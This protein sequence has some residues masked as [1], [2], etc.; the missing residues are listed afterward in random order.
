MEVE[1]LVRLRCG[2]YSW[3]CCIPPERADELS[4]F[5]R[6][7]SVSDIATILRWCQC[8]TQGTGPTQ[9]A[10]E[11]S[12]GT[13]NDPVAS[14]KAQLSTLT[15]PDVCQDAKDLICKPTVQKI[16]TAICTIISS[17]DPTKLSRP[18]SGLVQL[19]QFSCSMYELACTDDTSAAAFLLS[20]YALDDLVLR[21]VI[22]L[23]F[24]ITGYQ[25][26]AFMVSNIL[27]R[28]EAL[29]ADTSCGANLISA[30]KNITTMMQNMVTG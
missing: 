1:D 12:P 3:L 24:N 27:T 30:N 28:L 19:L 2:A 8:Q 15:L 7:H 17:A 16:V 18:Y 5:V 13:G 23:P 14:L 6:T 26:L 21:A 29:D 10:S 9:Q 25:A 4:I 11:Q 20:L 22:T